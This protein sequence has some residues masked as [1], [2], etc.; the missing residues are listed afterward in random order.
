MDDENE[1]ITP[2]VIRPE[3]DYEG[4][5]AMM[6]GESNDTT[7]AVPEESDEQIPT[8]PDEVDEDNDET[9]PPE[10][11]ETPD[12][13]EEELPP[14]END[15]DDEGGDDT[16]LEVDLDTVITLPDGTERTIEELTQ[17]FAD[18]SAVS[19]REAALKAK[20]DEYA[21][22][23]ADLSDKLKLAKLEADDVLEKFDG[24]DWNALLQ[25]SPE[26]FGK[27]KMFVE[28]YQKR[29]QEIQ[30]AMTDLNAKEAKKVEAA[31]QE[32]ALNCVRSLQKNI[33]GW[34]NGL[35]HQ[36]LEYAVN[37]GVDEKYITTCTD[38][39]VIKAFYDSMRLAKGENVVKAKVKKAVGSPKRVLSAQ[40]K[41]SAA[42]KKPVNTAGLQGSEV[43]EF[44]AF[45]KFI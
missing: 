38:A 20:E 40:A 31:N 32:K 25:E 15:E 9:P 5:L 1:V 41:K 36:I 23:Y 43:D 26:E 33:S 4:F 37:S 3:D 44:A 29:A 12:E 18:N 45:Q 17:G 30:K 24:F 13:E 10:D 34:N 27:T 7:P 22:Q 16:P 39:S 42:N 19:E 28:R 2:E 6:N 14:E 11:E 8:D 35:Y 21:S